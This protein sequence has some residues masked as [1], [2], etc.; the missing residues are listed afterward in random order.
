MLAAAHRQTAI[1]E[2]L[3]AAGAN[4]DQGNDD[5]S[6]ALM[7]AAY[8]G[9]RDMVEILLRAGA[10]INQQDHDGATALQ[11]AIQG[12]HPLV[13][14]LLLE[15]GADCYQANAQGDLPLSLVVA[16][17]NLDLLQCLNIPLDGESWLMA[18]SEGKGQMIKG[19]LQDHWPVDYQDDQGD[20]A[21]HLAC[22]EG[23]LDIVQQLL[24]AQAAVNVTN[25]A[26]DTPLMLAIAQGEGEIV[27]QLLAAGADPNLGP[28][29][30]SPL[31]I[32]LTTE[33]ISAATRRVIV[34]AL[35]EAGAEVGQPLIKI[36][37]QAVSITTVT[38][39]PVN[40]PGISVEHQE[41][42]K[43]R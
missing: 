28:V 32:A 23:H 6:T 24:Q 27:R 22:L 4:L 12:N 36:N 39:N 3:I 41:L 2:R 20:T 26:G 13:L 31:L 16:Q 9:D 17:D 30:E 37:G 1:A 29:G 10:E 35:R 25:Q 40:V 38:G 14:A 8:R 19:F 5:Q 7:I 34:A 21:L 15:Y 43:D 33:R 18:A 11:L 42:P